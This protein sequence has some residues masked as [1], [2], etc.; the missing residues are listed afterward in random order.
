MKIIQS[1]FN[2]YLNSSIHVAMAVYALTWITLIE[3]DLS[4]DK[5]ALYFVFFATITAYNFVKYFGL[6]KFHHRSLANRLRIIQVFSAIA[7]G[8]MCYYY[9]QLT[10]YVILLI[11][12]LALITFLYAIPLI[13]KRFLFDEQQNLRQIGGL[14]VYIIALVW[15][16][17]TVLIP[18]INSEYSVTTDVVITLFQRFCFVIVLMF[19]FEIRDLQYDSIKLA[20]IPQ[21]I[22]VKKTKIT[23]VLLLIVFIMLEF[24]KDE[25]DGTS[26]ISTLMITFLTLLFLVFSRE[27]QSKYYAAFWVEALPVFW[28]II[29]LLLS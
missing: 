14:K 1:V 25:L 22:G 21:K 19:P 27:K 29:L 6:A 23:G 7:F 20:T 8:V 26:V 16:L 13:P 24:F 9:F 12:I 15:S 10:S 28:L 11:G 2:F 17:V 3:F 5:N 4:Y 18:L